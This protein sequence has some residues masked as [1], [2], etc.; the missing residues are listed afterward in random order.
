MSEEGIQNILSTSTNLVENG[1]PLTEVNLPSFQN[2]S[3]NQAT[4]DFVYQ[5]ASKGFLSQSLLDDFVADFAETTGP[6]W[7]ASGNIRHDFFYS[8]S[9]DLSFKVNRMTAGKKDDLTFS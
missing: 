3:Y 2:P 9:S 4:L 6:D 8:S 7:T 1:A 5:A